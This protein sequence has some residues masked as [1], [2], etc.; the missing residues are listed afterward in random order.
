ML[1]PTRILYSVDVRLL[2][3]VG[4]IGTLLVWSFDQADDL[5]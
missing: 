3:F 2:R 5:D 4:E 1:R